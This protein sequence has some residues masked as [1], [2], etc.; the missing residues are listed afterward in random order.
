MEVTE[1]EE[2][3]EPEV[4]ESIGGSKT[5]GESSESS[6]DCEPLTDEPS[7]LSVTETDDG[8]R[9]GEGS[10]SSDSSSNDG[11]AEDISLG[12]LKAEGGREKCEVYRLGKEEC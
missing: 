7:Q 11:I 6:G 8:R 9:T 3:A 10:S 2:D 5:K 4:V 12:S 1:D